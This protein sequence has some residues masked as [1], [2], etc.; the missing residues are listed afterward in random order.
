MESFFCSPGFVSGSIRIKEKPQ[1]KKPR[2]NVIMYTESTPL[3]IRNQ[4]K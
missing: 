1:S 3:P 2:Y 4:I